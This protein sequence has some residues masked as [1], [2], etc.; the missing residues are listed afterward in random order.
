[1]EQILNQILIT[2]EYPGG[3]KLEGWWDVLD[4]LELKNGIVLIDIL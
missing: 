3:Y 4:N 2:Q 1:L